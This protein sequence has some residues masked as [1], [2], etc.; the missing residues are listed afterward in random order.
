MAHGADE[1]G[2]AGALQ[3]IAGGDGREDRGAAA[4]RAAGGARE[5]VRPV[6]P[7]KAR[8]RVSEGGSAIPGAPRTRPTGSGAAHTRITR[9]RS[10]AQQGGEPRRR[11]LA[12]A[13]DR[14]ESSRVGGADGAQAP[15]VAEEP[16]RE[17]RPDAGER[18]QDRQLLLAR[19]RRLGL[20]NPDGPRQSCCRGS[21]EQPNEAG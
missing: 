6:A 5:D 12:H 20:T 19:R 18:D 4:E 16:G 11:H 8:G 15:E 1:G 2:G 17:H 21:A 3:V 9:A 7:V 10:S 14:A 13:W